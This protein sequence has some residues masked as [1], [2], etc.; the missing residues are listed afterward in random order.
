MSTWSRVRWAHRIL[1]FR[2]PRILRLGS[3]ILT[4]HAPQNEEFRGHKNEDPILF[5]GPFESCPFF[6]LKAGRTPNLLPKKTKQNKNENKKR[7]RK[8]SFAFSRGQKKGRDMGRYDVVC[9]KCEDDAFEYLYSNETWVSS[10][11][12][13]V[14][15]PTPPE[16]FILAVN[17]ALEK[18]ASLI[19]SASIATYNG[20]FYWTQ[21]VM[22]P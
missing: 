21:T 1:V 13:Y 4:A 11:R 8:S 16:E 3:I 7:T 17:E 5:G 18:R 12:T 6:F 20:S 9:F 10:N 2:P 15:P 19:G 14:R 22:Y